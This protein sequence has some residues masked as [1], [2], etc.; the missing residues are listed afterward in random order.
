MPKERHAVSKIEKSYSI[1]KV[2]RKG[3]LTLWDGPNLTRAE[4]FSTV[5]QRAKTMPGET[6]FVYC[7]E[8]YYDRL[9]VPHKKGRRA[10]GA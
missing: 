7:T 3:S 1:L 2:T 6:F 4:A 8:R 10:R 5:K 9:L